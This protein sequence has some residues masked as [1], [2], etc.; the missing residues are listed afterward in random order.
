MKFKKFYF[1]AVIIYNF[2]FLIYRYVLLIGGWFLLGLLVYKVMNTEVDYVEWD[3][4]QI[5]ELKKVY[6]NYYLM[7]VYIRY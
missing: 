7:L 6:Y 3:P 5:M 1:L 2:F 4:Y